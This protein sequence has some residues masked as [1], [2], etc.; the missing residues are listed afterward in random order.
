M[1]EKDKEEKK[2]EKNGKKLG[3]GKRDY[4]E[5]IKNK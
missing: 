2:E 1:G 5:V 3:K 4:T